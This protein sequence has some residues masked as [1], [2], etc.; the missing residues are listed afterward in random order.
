MLVDC[1]RPGPSSMPPKKRIA[2]LPPLSGRGKR[3]L[4]HPSKPARAR[5][6]KR[7]SAIEQQ[8][9][10]F[11][12]DPTWR[13]DASRVM[14]SRLFE[15]AHVP[16]NDELRFGTTWD[17]PLRQN[18][19]RNY[20]RAIHIDAELHRNRLE[21]ACFP[22]SAHTDPAHARDTLRDVERDRHRTFGPPP[23]AKPP[24]I[25]RGS[26]IPIGLDFKYQERWFLGGASED[27]RAFYE[28]S[29]SRKNTDKYNDQLHAD[30]LFE[31]RK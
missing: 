25:E 21:E 14:M 12:M 29:K 2:A 3:T 28:A 20:E 7:V 19:L 8:L 16:F 31:R 23:D 26:D 5:D 24:Q 22:F 18:T 10:R 17:D 6:P 27:A 13:R 9:V 15:R 11:E 1:I 30:V 4:L